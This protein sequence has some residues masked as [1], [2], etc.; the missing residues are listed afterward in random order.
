MLDF[1]ADQGRHPDIENIDI[2]LARFPKSKHESECT[3]LLG[4]FLA[5]VDNEVIMKQEKG[6]LGQHSDRSP[7]NNV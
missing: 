2:I 7:Y 5:L 6:A 1:L 4:I 3:L